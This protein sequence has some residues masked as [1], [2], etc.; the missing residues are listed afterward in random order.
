MTVHRNRSMP[1]HLGTRPTRP[2]GRLPGGAPIRLGVLATALVIGQLVTG[3]AQSSASTAVPAAKL[4]VSYL[5]GYVY[6]RQA[7]ELFSKA[8]PGVSFDIEEA[9]S[10]TYQPLLDSQL[11]EGT[12]PDVIFTYGGHGNAV[13]VQELAPKGY[14]VDL[15]N[16][17]WV[18]SLP[19]TIRN[20]LSYKGHVY[21]ETTYIVPTGIVYNATLAQKL[22]VSKPTTFSGLL[23]WC[24]TVSAKGVVPIF[25]GLSSKNYNELIPGQLA[26]DLIYSTQP[27]WGVANKGAFSTGNTLWNRSLEHAM[28]QYVDMS[29]A[30][31]FEKDATGYSPNEAYSAIADGKALGTDIFT[32]GIPGITADKPNIKLGVFS[33][34]ATSNPKDTW[35]TGDLGLSMAVNVKSRYRPTALAYLAFLASPSIASAS[36]KANYGIPANPGQHFTAQPTLAGVAGQYMAGRYAFFPSTFYPNFNVKLTMEAQMQDL[37]NG[38]VTVPEALKAVKASY[39]TP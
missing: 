34:P 14:L 31:C 12:A 17:P 9:T 15:S 39:S 6:F 4:R 26:N 1:Q 18:K 28:Y 37:L 19:S 7:Q 3:V 36:A 35:V 27:N 30:N 2:K 22:G 11:T 23:G 29:K 20:D 33:V 21:A 25:M 38:T 8:H 16:Q 5:S 32:D 13:S 24:K 10:N